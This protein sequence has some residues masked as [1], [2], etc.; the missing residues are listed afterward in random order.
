MKWLIVVFILLV[1]GAIL[2][3]VSSGNAGYVLLQFAGWSV[4]TSVIALFI[5]TVT[6]VVV[7]SLV[8][9]LIRFV[10]RR[11]KS[12]GRWF[13]KRRN[14]KASRA[15]KEGQLALLDLNY[16]TA[17]QCFEKAYKRNKEPAF[18][19]LAS[20]SAQQQGELGKAEFWRSQA[21]KEFE[22]A[23][24]A[25]TLKYIDSI[26]TS[27]PTKALSLLEA[28]LNQKPSS[29][30]PW[31]LAIDLF[32]ANELWQRLID[33]LPALKSNTELSETAINEIKFEAFRRQ[34]LVER[35]VSA[36]ALYNY[37]RALDKSSRADSTIRLAYAAA[38]KQVGDKQ[39]CAKVIYK[40]LKRGDVSVEEATN[41]DV[42][43]ANYPKLVEFVQEAL[44]RNAQ[45]S[46][47]IR[48]LA[49]LAYDSKDYSL[50]QRALKK[51]VDKDATAS[52][53]QLLGD[54]Y[55]SL[56]DS[57]LAANAYKKALAAV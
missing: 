44:K 52:D 27:H 39:A 12:G 38:L 5:I 22:Q 49:M 10:L 32:K 25:L 15:F 23:D 40:G 56:G 2:G 53:Y 9:S 28:V 45:H 35:K 20:Y 31:L 41:S 48:A 33:V 4:E 13:G 54:I 16:L 17:L 50:A 29:A 43:C 11:G 34:F 46:G 3:P 24:Q 21:G 26:K 55:Q 57:Q 42:L 7:V 1:A 36:D 14:A 47:Y 8:V 19:A 51:L 18:A 37:W 30:Y 6:T